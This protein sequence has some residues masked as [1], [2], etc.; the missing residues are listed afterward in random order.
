M[1][2]S[3]NARH[4]EMGFSNKLWF[5]RLLGPGGMEEAGGLALLQQYCVCSG[6]PGLSVGA[7]GVRGRVWAVGT[8]SSMR[9]VDSY[10]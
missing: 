2:L 8:L 3:W 7:L 5:L 9:Q 4:L 10:W 6:S 1:F